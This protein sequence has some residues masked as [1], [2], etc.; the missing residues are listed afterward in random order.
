MTPSFLAAVVLLCAI[1][2]VSGD[3]C[4]SVIHGLSSPMRPSGFL[5]SNGT[6][7]SKPMHCS[8]TASVGNLPPQCCCDLGNSLTK[9]FPNIIIAGAQKSGSTALFSYM[10]FHPQFAPA[11]R[12][13]VHILDKPVMWKHEPVHAAHS[14]LLYFSNF[15]GSKVRQWLTQRVFLDGG[16]SPLHFL[17]SGSDAPMLCDS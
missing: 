15:N 11:S 13:D 1:R 9:C 17:F 16:Q 5:M 14:Y 6:E 12:K 8:A 10:L 3:P 7:A 4:G 2:W